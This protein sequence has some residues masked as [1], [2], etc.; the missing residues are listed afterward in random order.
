MKLIR[1]IGL[2]LVL[3]SHKKRLFIEAFIMLAWGRILKMIPF[4]KVAPTLGDR[5]QETSMDQVENK[6]ILKE[7][8]RSDPCHE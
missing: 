6:E 4:S 7:C 8:I 1:K 5:M 2:F 3:P